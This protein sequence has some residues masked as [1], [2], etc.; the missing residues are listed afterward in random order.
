MDLTNVA[1][2]IEYEEKIFSAK[3]IIAN[4]NSNSNEAGV[5][6]DGY[7]FLESVDKEGIR[8]VIDIYRKGE[9]FF[10]DSF[11][12]SDIENV[13]LTAKVK[14]RAFTFLHEPS[15]KINLGGLEINIVNE[16]INRQKIHLSHIHILGQ[17]TLRQKLMMFF[18]AERKRINKNP[19]KMEMSYADC[20]DYI[21]VDRSAMMREIN[22]MDRDGLIKHNGRYIEI[23]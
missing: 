17:H 1:S 4:S 18:I 3:E 8:R 15:K 2:I 11:P 13:Y 21:A 16:Y 7:A 22:W 6:I 19:F 10:V 5:I 23:L 9:P 12:S 20:A 14:C